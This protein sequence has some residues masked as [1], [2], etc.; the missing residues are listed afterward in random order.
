[1]GGIAVGPDKTLLRTFSVSGPVAG[2]G[3]SRAIPGIP[4]SCSPLWQ[5]GSCP[6]AR[7][8]GCAKDGDTNAGA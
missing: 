7:L 8:G 3:G 5:S 2:M 4:V 6:I 1:M